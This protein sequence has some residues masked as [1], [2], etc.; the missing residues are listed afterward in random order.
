MEDFAKKQSG[1]SYV[2]YFVR[3]FDNKKIY[4]LTCDQIAELLNTESGQTLGESAYRKEFAAFN[5]GRNYEREIAERGVATR[6]LSIS[7]L[8]FPFAKP[9]ETFS[10]YV[11]RVD[12]LQLNGDI[13]DCQS[14]SKFSKSYRIP[15]IEEL[16]E[17]RQYIIDLIDYINRRRSSQTTA[18]MSFASEHISPTTSIQTFRS[19]CLRR[20]W[21]TSSLMVSIITTVAI[22]LRHGLSRCVR[23]SMISKSFILA[24]GFRR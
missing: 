7:D 10:K 22:I 17:G 9:I 11:G 12:I 19:L 4:G 5:R 18:T 14:I 13:F 1:E 3:L 20:H 24:S 6:V 2:D 15:C 23:H 8:H 21:T 16:V